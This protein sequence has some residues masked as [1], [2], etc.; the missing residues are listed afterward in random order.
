MI[1]LS[2]SLT[3]SFSPLRDISSKIKKICLK[4]SKESP[5]F[6]LLVLY[7]VSSFNF[8]RL[9]LILKPSQGFTCITKAD[10]RLDEML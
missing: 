2:L 3:V 4:T 6:Q 10:M 5:F 1:S 9:S 7:Q 8:L